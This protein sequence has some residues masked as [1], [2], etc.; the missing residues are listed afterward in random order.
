[1]WL[2]TAAKRFKVQISHCDMWA[3]DVFYYKI[4]YGRKPVSMKIIL[5]FDKKEKCDIGKLLSFIWPTCW[6]PTVVWNVLLQWKHQRQQKDEIFS[7]R[8][9]QRIYIFHT[10]KLNSWELNHSSCIWSES[11]RLC[12]CINHC[13][14]DAWWRDR[15]A[16]NKRSSRNGNNFP[17]ICWKF[18]CNNENII[19][20]DFF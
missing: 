16:K 20:K 8:K 4:C 9:L 12:H 6:T 2:Q 3:A 11:C 7:P 17:I 13:S 14:W 18:I 5:G 10:S 15:P 1:M 19:Y